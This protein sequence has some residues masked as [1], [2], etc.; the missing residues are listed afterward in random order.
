F[1]GSPRRSI[2][3]SIPRYGHQ[4]THH[5]CRLCTHR[6]ILQSDLRSI[7]QYDLLST[8]QLSHQCRHQFI[9][10][11]GAHMFRRLSWGAVP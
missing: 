9:R 3:Q 8:L 6:S 2:P 4:Y 7:L 11:H 1:L 10:H 5:H